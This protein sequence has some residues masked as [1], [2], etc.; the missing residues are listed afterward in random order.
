MNDKALFKLSYGLYLLTA[1]EEDRVNGCIVNT[2][3]Q[4]ANSPTRVSIAV[5]KQNLTHDMILAT[6]KCA[7]TALSVSTPFD[8]FKHFGFQSGRNVDKFADYPH[9]LTGEGLP[10]LTGN[11]CA[12]L[13][14]HV[15]QTMDLGSHTLF[16]AEVVDA[17][18]L[19]KEDA[20]TY[21]YYHK[22]IKPAPAKTEAKKTGWRCTIC[23]YIHEEENLP[24]D[25]VCPLCKHG[26]SDFEKLS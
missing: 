6:G 16:I 8:L 14:C 20:L 22:N 11:A 13:V 26:A 25:F 18:I 21:D 15:T 1:K 17:D 19:S 23:G 4:V 3:V 5:N 10:Y 12:Y 9:S 7:V 24:A 2:V